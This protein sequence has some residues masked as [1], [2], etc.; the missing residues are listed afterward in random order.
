MSGH[1]ARCKLVALLVGL[2]L[3]ARSSLAAPG[4]RDVIDQTANQVLVVLRDKSLDKQQKIHRI[5]E[6]VYARF[7]F[8][9]ISRLVLA[10]NWGSLS[11]SQK[12]AFVKEFKEHLSVTYGRNVDS[13]NNEK[14]VVGSDRE[15]ARGDWTVKTKITRSTG[16]DFQV[17]YRLRQKD[18]EWKVIDVVIEG[19]S[20]IANFRS[21]FQDIISNGGVDH[22][23]T[24][25]REKNAAGETIVENPKLKPKD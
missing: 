19:V 23:I 24:L 7:D 3:V 20:L 11:D 1:S 10:R 13:Y 14:V 9:T 21:Q 2:L 16:D 12:S 17:D 6:I 5:E 18:G 15:E 22:L 8:D 25:L 4:P